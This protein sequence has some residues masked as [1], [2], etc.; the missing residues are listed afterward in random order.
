[1]VGI[2]P[3][4]TEKNAIWADIVVTYL[5]LLNCDSDMARLPHP[6]ASIFKGVIGRGDREDLYVAGGHILSLI[7]QKGSSGC[8]RSMFSSKA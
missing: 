2:V 5:G 3:F 8:V 6:M 4:V 1:M 7:S